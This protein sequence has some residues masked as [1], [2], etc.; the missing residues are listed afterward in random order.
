MMDEFL[1]LLNLGIDYVTHRIKGQKC[2]IIVESKVSP[3]LTFTNN[4]AYLVTV[5]YLKFIY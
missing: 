3:Y 2:I 1:N 5:I 4:I